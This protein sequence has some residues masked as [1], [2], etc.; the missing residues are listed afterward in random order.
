MMIRPLTATDAARYQ[1][2]RLCALW[3]HPE[4]FASA[5]EDEQPLPLGTVAHRLQQSSA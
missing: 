2:L 1:P 4:A 5:F 3:E